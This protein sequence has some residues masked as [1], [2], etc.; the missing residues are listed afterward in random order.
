MTGAAAL[1]AT[2]RA[3]SLAARGTDMGGRPEPKDLVG[4]RRRFPDV[5]EWCQAHLPG[6]VEKPNQACAER[7]VDAWVKRRRGAPETE[8]RML[9]EIPALKRSVG[10][11]AAPL[12]RARISGAAICVVR[13]LGERRK[14]G[15]HRPVLGAPGASGAPPQLRLLQPRHHERGA[16]G[17]AV[18]G[19][20]TFSQRED[21]RRELDGLRR[22][23][24]AEVL[25]RS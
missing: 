21:P 11:H 19:A 14:P 1:S 13:M 22:L 7:K 10:L 24:R 23:V 8:G 2:A 18:R 3:E 20:T 4:E 16:C 25:R 5:E 15:P 9:L 12:R 6:L 17:V